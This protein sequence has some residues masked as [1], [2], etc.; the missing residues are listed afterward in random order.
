MRICADFVVAGGQF[1]LR[2]IARGAL[3]PPLGERLP[4]SIFNRKKEAWR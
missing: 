4:Q 2:K 1:F 3:P